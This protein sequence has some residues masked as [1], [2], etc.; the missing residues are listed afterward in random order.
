MLRA[1][2]SPPIG[3]PPRRS[4][5]PETFCFTLSSALAETEGIVKVSEQLGQIP[6]SRSEPKKAVG[7]Y[8]DQVSI[9]AWLGAQ[10]EPLQSKVP[11]LC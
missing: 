5:K 2:V 6:L 4:L 7:T 10:E 9:S 1:R 11:H 8:F 3:S